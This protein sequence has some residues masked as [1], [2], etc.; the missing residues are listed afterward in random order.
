MGGKLA[1]FRLAAVE[2]LHGGPLVVPAAGHDL[3]VAVVVVRRVHPALLHLHNLAVLVL[4]RLARE[5]V[6]VADDF[7]LEVVGHVAEEFFPVGVRAVFDFEDGFDFGGGG[8]RGGHFGD[9]KSVV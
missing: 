4:V 1:C 3:D 7:E 2:Q 5:R 8:V 6:G 9:R